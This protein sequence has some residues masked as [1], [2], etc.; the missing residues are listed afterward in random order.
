MGYVTSTWLEYGFIC[1]NGPS[2]VM[3]GRTGLPDVANHLARRFVTGQEDVDVT[4]GTGWPVGRQI[5]AT[6]QGWSVRYDQLAVE[7]ER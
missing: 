4:G 1:I 3:D 5:D 7:K 6:S 2:S